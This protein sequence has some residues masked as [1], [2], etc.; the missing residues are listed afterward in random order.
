MADDKPHSVEGRIIW[1]E[2]QTNRIIADIESEKGT[3]Q[4]VNIEFDKMIRELQKTVWKG[5]GGLIVIQALI[6]WAIALYLSKGH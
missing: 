6:G 2:V 1:L 4:R 5:V 3:R